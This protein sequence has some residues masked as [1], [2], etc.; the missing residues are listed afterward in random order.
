MTWPHSLTH[1]SNHSLT[2]PPWM[3][4]SLQIINLQTELNYLDSVNIFYIFSVLTWP[5]PSTHQT[6][7][8]PMGGKFFTDFKSLNRIEISWLVQLSNFNWFHGSTPLGGG[9]W[10]DGGGGG[11]GCVWGVPCMHACMHTYAYTCMHTRTCMLNMLNMD[12]SMWVAICNFY[13]CIYVCVCMCMCVHVGTPPMPQTPPTHL[14]SPQSCRELKTPKFNKSWTNRDNLILFEDSL[15]LNI[16]ELIYTIVDHPRHPHLSVKPPR[17]EET[18]IRRITITLEWIE[19]IQFCLKIC[20]PW[21]L[22]HTYRLGLM[23]RWGVSYL[24]WHFY[25]FDP[26]KCSLTLQ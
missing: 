5:H 15:L 19:I 16:P 10:V 23:C 21:T 12:A 4:V 9:G 8:P 7:H 22:L 1:P 2:H 6:I 14:P 13:T 17:A 26:I 20:D 11:Y 25:V 24:K 18:Q 3:G